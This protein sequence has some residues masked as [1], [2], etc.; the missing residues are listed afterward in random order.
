MKTRLFTMLALC[1]SFLF[2]GLPG[3]EAQEVDTLTVEVVGYGIVAGVGHNCPI[4][5]NGKIEAYVG[6][7]ISCPVWV[8]D[9]D[10]DQTPGT[11]NIEVS[12]SRFVEASVVGDSVLNIR[13]LQ[14]GN[15]HIRLY[16]TPKL[17]HAAIHFNREPS[18]D[19]IPPFDVDRNGTVQFCAYLGKSYAE[20]KMVSEVPDWA[21]ACPTFG[22]GELPT[23]PVFWSGGDGMLV[24]HETDPRAPGAKANLTLPPAGTAPQNMNV[25][26]RIDLPH[27]FLG[28]FRRGQN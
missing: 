15:T 21:P 8:V 12:D 28:L 20:A 27:Q 1:A 16:P 10:G 24:W 9:S 14:K 7:E 23:F 5:D 2:A 26:A 25:Q 4:A 3:A 13:V 22:Q 19:T 6:V 18:L 11:I 17:L